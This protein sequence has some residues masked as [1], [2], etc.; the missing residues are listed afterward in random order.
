MAD[1]ASSPYF[2]VVLVIS[3]FALPLIFLVWIRNTARYS[4]EPWST[5]LRAFAWGAVFSVIIAVVF[6]LIFLVTLGQVGPLYEF[7]ARRFTRPLD[8]IGAV[9]VAP[10]VEEA[11]KG[12]GVRA[13]RSQTQSKFDGIVYGAAAGL[14]FSATENLLNGIVAL[15]RPELGPSG[16]LFVIAVRSF[17]SSFLHAS[18]S[19][20][21]GYGLAKTWL[22]GRTG[23][24]LPFYIL[25][26]LMHMAFNFLAVVGATYATQYGEL[27]EAIAFVAAVGFAVTA[28]TIVR[29]KLASKPPVSVR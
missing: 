11:A 25:A 28:I 14:G 4:K 6:N 23:A 21:M 10:F 20:V 7:F 27:G 24:F 8:V 18:A 2:L 16:S 3:A 15:A 26:V 22:S 29:L 19:A 13:G 5:V 9:L 12:L 17:S 1:L